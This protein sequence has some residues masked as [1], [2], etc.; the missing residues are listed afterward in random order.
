MSN[1]K[2]KVYNS[3]APLSLWIKAVSIAVAALFFILFAVWQSSQ[4]IT[5]AKITGTVI[6]KEFKPLDQVDK[7][8]TIHR[9]G[10]VRTDSVEGDYI[11][12]VAVPQQSGQP[13]NYTV[14]LNDKQRYDSTKV[15]DSFDVGPY[16][17]KEPSP[18]K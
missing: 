12:T 9:T 17:V 2:A 13:K 11:I 8:I 16:L 5:N 7:Q 15:G 10:V 1:P 18:Q 4:T 14:W 6:S 3:P